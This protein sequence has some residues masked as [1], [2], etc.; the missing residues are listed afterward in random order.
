[1]PWM[2]AP[3]P[4][5]VSTFA[6]PPL[7]QPLR[8]Q[9]PHAHKQTTPNPTLQKHASVPPLAVPCVLFAVFACTPP[10]GSS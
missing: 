10:L 4:P 8:P 9:L 6:G 7:Q 1:M 5:W 3:E 2:R